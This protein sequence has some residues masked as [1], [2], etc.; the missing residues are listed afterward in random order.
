MFKDC[1]TPRFGNIDG[2]KH[3]NNTV[4]ADW[5]EI[6]RN[7]IFRYFTP[8][9][10][11]SYEK[12]K[13]IMVRTEF[14]FVSQMYFGEDVE[15]RTYVLKIGNSSF[16]TGHEAWQ[17]GELKSKGKAVIVHYDFIEKKSVPIPNEIKGKLRN[18]LIDETEIGKP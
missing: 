13:L 16:T 5:F 9:L 12:W 1:V 10:D 11:L 8:D 3:V 4:V 14:D 2:L 6:G 18:H 17:N 15:I 7:G